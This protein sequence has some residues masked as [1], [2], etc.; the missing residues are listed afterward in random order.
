MVKKKKKSTVEKL[1]KKFKKSRKTAQQF[2]IDVGIKAP[3][4][5]P[6]KK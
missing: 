4:K 6:K 2:L 1:V 3:I 5:K